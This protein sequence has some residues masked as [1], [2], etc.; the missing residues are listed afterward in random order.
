M[1]FTARIFGTKIPDDFKRGSFFFPHTLFFTKKSLIKLFQNLEFKVI[2]E[3]EIY[4]DFTNKKKQN[5]SIHKEENK[6]SLIT[7]FYLFC[8]KFL[9]EKFVK[10]YAFKNFVINGPASNLPIIRMIVEK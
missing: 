6:K 1:K 9:P 7:K 10:K 2:A 3:S 4:S 8:Q 5:I